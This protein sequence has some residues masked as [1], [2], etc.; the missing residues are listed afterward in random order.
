MSIL[1][2]L[3]LAATVGS[4]R[5][6][7][8][9]PLVREAPP[10]LV[11]WKDLSDRPVVWLGKTVRLQV[12]FSHRVETWNPYLTRFGPRQF[13]GVQAWTDEQ[14]PWVKT[15][16]DSP[17]VRVFFRTGKACD[18]ALEGAKPGARFELT[19]IV[20]EIFLD[21]P[22]VEV[23]E[24][25]P[26]LERIGEGTSIHAGKAVDLM[27]ARSFALAE[28]EFQQAITDDLPIGARAE[29]ERLLALCHDA[30]ALDK[31][32]NGTPSARK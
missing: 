19:G 2:S 31:R 32:L 18:W 5:P 9:L 30:A 22:W 15:E 8:L 14:F 25:R 27:T 28:S 1:V 12:Q 16:Y 26:L 17:A 6:P 10:P 24:V 20:R 7:V 29:L 21:D 23:V 3:L 11:T 13:T 4:G